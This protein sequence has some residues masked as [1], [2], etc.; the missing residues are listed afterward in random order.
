MQEN[1]TVNTQSS[2]RIESGRVIYVDPFKLNGPSR[3]ADIILITHKH[4][5]HFSPEDCAKIVK[6][7]TRFVAPVSVGDLLLDAGIPSKQ[8]TLMKPGESAEVC[9][10]SIEAVPS[11]NGNKPMH[12][13]EYGWLGYVI[14]VDGKRIYVAGD[15]DDIPEGRAVKCD[16]AMVPIG[17][18]YTMDAKEAAEFVN[19]MSPAAVIP[20]HYGSIVGELSDAQVFAA[21]LSPDIELCLKIG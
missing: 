12:L 13:K 19:A 15:C 9:G 16:I 5:D 20:T 1:I 7:G 21:H 3:D 10:V 8:I 14:T 17:G 18:T 11:Y 4:Y 6:A 2:I